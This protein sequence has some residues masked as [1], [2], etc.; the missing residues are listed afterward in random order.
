M[1][2]T[3]YNPKGKV[4]FSSSFFH[5]YGTRSFPMA[6]WELKCKIS[7]YDTFNQIWNTSKMKLILLKV[8]LF[9][10]VLHS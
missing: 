9:V 6:L 1:Y 5:L 3:H 10:F 2:W 8:Q 7:N 4:F